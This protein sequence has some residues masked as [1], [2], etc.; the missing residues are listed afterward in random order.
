MNCAICHGWIYTAISGWHHTNTNE[1]NPLEA[2]HNKCEEEKGVNMQIDSEFAHQ[3]FYWLMQQPTKVQLDWY[4]AWRLPDES[5]I[6]IDCDEFQG[7][8]EMTWYPKDKQMNHMTFYP[9][10]W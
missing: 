6:A 10:N 1:S 7:W 3:L 4:W 5:L 2:V 9:L 8:G